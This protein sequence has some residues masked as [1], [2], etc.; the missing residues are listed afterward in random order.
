M[1]YHE[2]PSE[3]I[4]ALNIK[5]CNSLSDATK[6]VWFPAVRKAHMWRLLAVSRLLLQ[7]RGLTFERCKEKSEKQWLTDCEHVKPVFISFLWVCY[8]AARCWQASVRWRGP[9]QKMS[10]LTQE[11]RP[12]GEWATNQVTHNWGHVA[13]LSLGIHIWPATEMC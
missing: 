7:L 1:H 11:R 2:F 13:E 9:Q 3:F 10:A 12:E 4:Y 8:D 5:Y 6:V